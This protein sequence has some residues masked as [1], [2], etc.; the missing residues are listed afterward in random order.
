MFVPK[1]L[2]WPHETFFLTRKNQRRL[3]K[4][5]ITSNFRRAAQDKLFREPT[6]PKNLFSRCRRRRKR[7]E[8]IPCQARNSHV[9][10][11]KQRYATNPTAYTARRQPQSRTRQPTQTRHPK[12][13]SQA[14]RSQEASRRQ[15]S[16][17]IRAKRSKDTRGEGRIHPQII[18]HMDVR[19]W[20]RQNVNASRGRKLS[21]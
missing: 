2:Y 9:C 17:H 4:F 7:N 1:T 5:D 19:K 21:D 12:P 16:Q 14:I 10:K 15:T 20:A 18:K 11:A 6:V 3:P 13:D 8:A